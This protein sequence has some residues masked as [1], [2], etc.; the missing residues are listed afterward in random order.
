MG[1]K[2]SRDKSWQRNET[3]ILAHIFAAGILLFC[4]SFFFFANLQM[5]LSDITSYMAFAPIILILGVLF[6]CF[7]IVALSFYLYEAKTVWLADRYDLAYK[8]IFSITLVL[9]IVR[10]FLGDFMTP[11]VTDEDG[12]TTGGT[13]LNVPVSLVVACVLSGIMTWCLPKIRDNDN[14]E[15]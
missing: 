9:F 7:Y 14:T 2:I 11:V 8:I 10:S 12:N 3:I 1:G 15:F 4:V 5:F 13:M 6:V